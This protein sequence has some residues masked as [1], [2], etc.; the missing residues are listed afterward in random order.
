MAHDS[1]AVANYFLDRA[2]YLGRSLNLIKLPNSWIK[3]YYKKQL[4]KCC[5]NI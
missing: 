4:K 3:K 1:R 2:K 5:K